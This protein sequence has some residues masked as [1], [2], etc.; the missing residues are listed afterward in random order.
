MKP[1]QLLYEAWKYERRITLV[2][3]RSEKDLITPCG[4]RIIGT[5]QA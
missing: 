1:S 4:S 5:Q 3:C 2:R